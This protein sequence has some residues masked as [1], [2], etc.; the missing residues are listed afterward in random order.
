MWPFGNNKLDSALQSDPFVQLIKDGHSSDEIRELMLIK[1]GSLKL[2]EMVS[3]INKFSKY[4]DYRRYAVNVFVQLCIDGDVEMDSSI[5]ACRRAFGIFNLKTI[6]FTTKEIEK[7]LER[8]DVL[9]SVMSDPSF[10]TTKF[11][12]E[13]FLYDRYEKRVSFPVKNSAV[14]ITIQSE[15]YGLTVVSFESKDRFFQVDSRD[16]R[17]VYVNENKLVINNSPVLELE[18]KENFVNKEISKLLFSKIERNEELPK[19]ESKSDC[20]SDNCTE[21]KVLYGIVGFATG[22]ALF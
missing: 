5:N 1:H 14:N 18:P 9:D 19:S 3:L 16:V 15:K 22:A 4:P 17:S 7:G 2:S 13:Q 20:K 12:L 21:D 6:G 11:I 8:H 10:F